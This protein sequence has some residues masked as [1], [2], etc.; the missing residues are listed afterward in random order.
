MWSRG[1]KQVAHDQ[2]ILSALV[3]L[4]PRLYRAI[5][6]GP[7]TLRSKFPDLILIN[8]YI[9]WLHLRGTLQRGKAQF[10]WRIDSKQ[11]AIAHEHKFDTVRVA[12]LQC[13]Q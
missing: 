12:L 7:V 6:A 3:M 9:V 2:Y 10:Q 4:H 1:V 11:L 8:S 13:C 5:K